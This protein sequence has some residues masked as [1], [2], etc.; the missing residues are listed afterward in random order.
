[1][2]EPNIKVTIL[3]NEG[4]LV[5]FLAEADFNAESSIYT[6]IPIDENSEFIEGECFNCDDEAEP[7]YSTSINDLIEKYKSITLQEIKKIKIK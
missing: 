3:K 4:I 6:N 7:F 2:I 1:M 5:D